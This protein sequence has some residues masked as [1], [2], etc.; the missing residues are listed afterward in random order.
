MV[1]ITHSLHIELLKNIKTK[2]IETK[3][4]KKK[5]G[6]EDAGPVLLIGPPTS[7][8]IAYT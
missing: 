2:Y 7:R 3:Y 4:I 6:W 1:Q 5:I 8:L